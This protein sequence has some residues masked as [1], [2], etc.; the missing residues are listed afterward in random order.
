MKFKKQNK[1]KKKLNLYNKRANNNYFI[2]MYIKTNKL[3]CV[4]GDLT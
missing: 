4:A 3:N 2:I 1:I